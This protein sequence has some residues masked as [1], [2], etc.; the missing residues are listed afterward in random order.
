MQDLAG[1]YYSAAVLDFDGNSIEVMHRINACKST[2]G[3]DRAPDD[4]SV[5]A[6][7]Q[8][9]AK[10]TVPAQGTSLAERSTAR[11]YVNNVAKPSVVVSQMVPA[12]ATSSGNNEQS[13]TALLGTLLGA[14]AGAAVAYAMTK[15]ETEDAKVKTARQTI[16][17]RTVEGPPPPAPLPAEQIPSS[18]SS[19]QSYSYAC[20]DTSARTPVRALDYPH[21]EHSVVSQVPKSHASASR[22]SHAADSKPSQHMLALPTSTLIETFVPPSEAPR[23]PS[24]QLLTRSQ[25]NG[26]LPAHSYTG[27]QA[28]RRSKPSRSSSDPETV[29]ATHRH[30]SHASRSPPSKALRSAINQP[31]PSS[32]A[33]SAVSRL[34]SSK[35]PTEEPSYH[36]EVESVAPS[37][38]ISQ[39][40]SMSR[41]SKASKRSSK[42]RSEIEVDEVDTHVSVSTV[43]GPGNQARSKHR[44]SATSLPMRPSRNIS[45]HRSV[46]SYVVG[47]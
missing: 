7:Q 30:H 13:S 33:T 4:R 34:T 35:V 44:G 6:W 36:V 47:R 45:A 26:A 32:R 28:S 2:S 29:I 24:A 19:R 39:V 16:I 15:A 10:R 46:K 14:A 22:Y 21:A 25:T 40:G 37:D 9:V 3:H 38:S 5:L 20:S 42:L 18:F 43:T 11:V 12:A 17:Y 41:R 27:T 1:T 31:L 23:Y 8:D